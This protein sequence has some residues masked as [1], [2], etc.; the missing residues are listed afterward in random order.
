[1]TTTFQFKV[2]MPRRRRRPAPANSGGAVASAAAPADLDCV[3]SEDIDV[4]L[5]DDLVGAPAAATDRPHHGTTYVRT[6]PEL[7]YSEDWNADDL[8]GCPAAAEDRDEWYTEMMDPAY[9][10]S[11]LVPVVGRAP[12]ECA[13]RCE[14]AEDELVQ[15]KS[16]L[17]RGLD[18]VYHKSCLDIQA[19]HSK[20]PGK[21]L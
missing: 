21:T 6:G 12:S 11:R 10:P 14:K 7:W 16:C 2:V 5:S 20:Y 4:A 13:L 17:F 1:M 19:R 18:C 15:S 3:L 8:V 9:D